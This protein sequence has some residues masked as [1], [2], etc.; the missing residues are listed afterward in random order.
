MGYQ[1]GFTVL[2]RPRPEADKLASPN[3]KVKNEWSYTSISPCFFIGCTGTIFSQTLTRTRD[4]MRN[5]PYLA[6]DWGRINTG[7]DRFS[8]KH[9]YVMGVTA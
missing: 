1:G 9:V 8:T 3:V 2:N 7:T 4:F 6:L 5:V